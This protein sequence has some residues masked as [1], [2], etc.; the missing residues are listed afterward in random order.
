MPGKNL[1]NE[2]IDFL[3]FIRTP[4]ASIKIGGEILKDVF[5]MLLD[6]YYL[7]HQ[8]IGTESKITSDNRLKNLPI[9]IDGI[10]KETKRISEYVQTLEVNK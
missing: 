7:Y 4:L 6:T 8:N 3:H 1:E 5:P 9:I 2:I 10:I